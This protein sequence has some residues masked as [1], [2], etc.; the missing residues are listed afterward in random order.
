M[1][2]TL[3]PEE[4]VTWTIS[5]T[6][7]GSITAGQGTTNIDVLWNND[8][9]TATLT[10]D[11]CGGT[12][13]HSMMIQIITPPLPIITGPASLCSG[14]TGTVNVTGNYSSSSL[15]CLDQPGLSFTT[16]AT[17][18]PAF[19]SV[20]G[21]CCYL[22]KG[23]DTT[24]GCELSDTICID[25]EGPTAEI[26]AL[27]TLRICEDAMG[28]PIPI[29]L[30]LGAAV[31]SG[32]TYQWEENCSGTWLPIGGGMSAIL[33]IPMVATPCS[34]RCVITQ[35]A[36]TEVSNILNTFQDDCIDTCNAEPYT[37]DFTFSDCGPSYAFTSTSSANVSSSS[38]FWEFG[39]GQIGN[40]ITAN[41]SYDNVG[42]Y[43]VCVNGKVPDVNGVDSCIVEYCDTLIVPMVV[44]WEWQFD[45]CSAG[46]AVYKF[47]NLTLLN[48]QN[49]SVS[50][51][52]TFTDD[53][54]SS[55]FTSTDE[56]PIENICSN[57]GNTVPVTLEVTTI[58][59]NNITCIY[60]VTKMIDLAGSTPAGMI[61][62]TACV[63]EK[64]TFSS[65][66][67]GAV[68]WLWDF[69][70]GAS[71]ALE[72]PCRTYTSPNTYTVTLKTKD[73]YGCESSTNFSQSIII[74]PTPSPIAIIAAPSGAVCA[75][76]TVT[77]TATPSGMMNYEWF[78]G[79]TNL[80]LQSGPSD[81]YSVTTTG[82]YYV[83]VK[84]NNNCKEKSADIPIT[85]F[86]FPSIDIAGN[87]EI[88]LGDALML[89]ATE[90]YNYDW[91]WSGSSLSSINELNYS[92]LPVGNHIIELTIS[93]TAAPACSTVISIP[94]TV[95]NSPAP[96]VISS[97]PT[98]ACEG[99]VVVLSVVPV[100]G[101]IYSWS[102]GMTGSTITLQPALE[103]AISVTATDII[104]GCSATSN[105]TYVYP[106]PDVCVVPAGCFEVCNQDT[107]CLPD[108]F[109]AYQWLK[110]GVPIPAS[111][112]NCITITESG[113]YQVILTSAVGCVDTSD[114]MEYT[115]LNC[116]SGCVEIVEIIQK[117]VDCN[118]DSLCFANPFCQ[119]WLRN[120]I[121]TT[122]NQGCTGLYLEYVNKAYWNGQPV[123]ITQSSS[124]PDRDYSV[125]YNCEGDTLQICQ[126]TIAGPVCNP[127]LST[128]DIFSQLTNVTR[129]W[130]CGN[131]LPPLGP[132]C[133]QNFGAS[134]EYCLVVK[135]KNVHPAT[136][137]SIQPSGVGASVTVSP[138]GITFN[139]PLAPGAM[140][141]IDLTLFTSVALP[142]DTVKLHLGLYGVS[143]DFLFDW[144]CMNED[145]LCLVLP[146]CPPDTCCNEN[147]S[148]IAN[149]SFSGYPT[150]NL[151]GTGSPWIPT[152]RTPQIYNNDGCDSLGYL[153]M[154]GNELVGECT[155]QRNLNI[156]AGNTYRLS[157]CAKYIASNSQ[158]PNWAKIQVRAG[159]QALPE[160][161]CPGIC[162]EIYTTPEISNTDWAN[163]CFEWTPQN[164]YDRISLRVIND[165]NIDHG[166]YVSY[167]GIDDVCL[168]L[169][170]S[171]RECCTDYN[172]FCEE[173]ENQVNID[174][175][176]CKVTVNIGDLQECT[177]IND[178][179]WGDGTSENGPFTNGSMPMHTYATSGSYIISWIVFERDSVGDI[180]FEKVF[181][182]TLQINCEMD[183][184]QANFDWILA[185]DCLKINLTST[186]IGSGNLTYEWLV[187][188]ITIANT[189]NTMW[190]APDTGVYEICLAIM[191][192][193]GCKDTLCQDIGIYDTTPP[194][195]ICP[196]DINETIPACDRGI[197]VFFD[198]PIATD[199]CGIDSVW[200]NYESGAFFECGGTPVT[201]Y[202][203]DNYGNIDSCIF[204]ITVYCECATIVSGEIACSRDSAT[205]YDFCIK[206][207]K[208]NDAVNTNC[209]ITLTSN[210]SGMV[211]D[212]QTVNWIHPD[213]AEVCGTIS[214]IRPI[215]TFINLGVNFSC[216][217]PDGQIA[218]CDL[219]YGFNTPCCDSVYVES[220]E[221]CHQDNQLLVPLNGSIDFSNIAQTIWYVSPAP[222]PTTPF[223]GTPYQVNN[224]YADLLLLP[225]YLTG[226][227]CIYAEVIMAN[228]PCTKLTSNLDSIEICQPVTCSMQD[229]AY[230]YTGIPIIPAPI[231][232][233]L[234]TNGQN[235]EY[236]IIW[237]DE[238]GDT[239][240]GENGLKYQPPAI[241]FMGA[242]D[243]CSY[244][245]T[246]T[247]VINSVCGSSNCTATIRLDNDNAAVG[248][249]SLIYPS[250]AMPFCPGQDATIQYN[251]AC[252]G[253]PPMWFWHESTDGT[254]FTAIPAAGNQN[255]VYNTNRLFT[256]TWFMVTKQASFKNKKK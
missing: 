84:D 246:Y 120:Q 168:E 15:V 94:V 134:Y 78:D 108:Y 221:V 156:E 26:F 244:A 213:T 132:D 145:T 5:P 180:C 103:G 195:I 232:I 91:K 121:Q 125:I 105:N 64:V 75:G 226:D 188:G 95:H 167:A 133:F 186:A 237:K 45:G 182:D 239:I 196:N 50:Y 51:L 158:A 154:W 146:P 76:E 110:D 10:A 117:E 9:G 68:E 216:I 29:D 62:L 184:C 80:S 199:S 100:A 39:D 139:P 202:A 200:C 137:I 160:A 189:A 115:I 247:A 93:Q 42:S 193:T 172:A 32:Y 63:G 60:T 70:D 61:P 36:C 81:T 222:C 251:P 161:G 6:T 57:C 33:N 198:P 171:V 96:P 204:V 116:D 71:S 230:C 55:T 192:D 49:L 217:C 234:D 256:T 240:L 140:D 179:F 74:H 129:I 150:A 122:I 173:I 175:D 135:N 142:G 130:D 54:T 90:G 89:T 19:N 23:I 72:N 242:A 38:I 109:A 69:G 224:G 153:Y 176:T 7:L 128:I 18:N 164:D 83:E 52:W 101:L 215:P 22:F 144:G 85:V 210:Q 13:S 17:T 165:Q 3:P 148:L 82:F 98:T 79:T 97:V 212:N 250:T 174:I 209:T 35:G 20:I 56:H 14:T 201:C 104:T 43:F 159:N 187:D 185:E 40:G 118:R 214:S 124:V 229:T 219:G 21:G 131:P 107:I 233:E 46:P 16:G 92:L 194:N 177:E 227:V 25:K 86:E 11:Y 67:C 138:S 66:S 28:N 231:C 178:I 1:L 106:L 228:G 245:V 87:L 255:P 183:S 99:D 208:L 119:N 143:S 48:P 151:S 169:T 102:N 220:Q 249:L 223:G 88:C 65:T 211:V 112:D 59:K 2:G 155:E 147:N 8:M 141:T 181:R 126:G 190:T 136:G 113:D 123:I 235:C 152:C 111:M 47:T 4:E 77:L 41:H 243:A 44:D 149:G 252:V 248:Q 37:L 114:V 162:E 206:V 241:D 197:N 31:G 253:E 12:I 163:Y 127:L 236:T 24:T 27:S 203:K 225:S 73:E 30:S 58:D 238:N 207:K 157:F 191:D 166:E 53:C 34:Y 218:E 254:N 170:K 205:S